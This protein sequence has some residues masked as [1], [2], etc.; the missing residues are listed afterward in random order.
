MRAV[1][2]LVGWRVRASIPEPGQLEVE[3]SGLPLAPSVE[4]AQDD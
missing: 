1:C 3:L 2:E 4:L